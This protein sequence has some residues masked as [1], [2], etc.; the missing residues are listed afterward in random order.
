MQQLPHALTIDVEQ[1]ERQR[2]GHPPN[3]FFVRQPAGCRNAKQCAQINREL[4]REQRRLDRLRRQYD[5]KPWRSSDWEMQFMLDPGADGPRSSYLEVEQTSDQAYRVNPN[6][7]LDPLAPEDERWTLSPGSQDLAA[8]AVLADR[9]KFRVYP[10]MHSWQTT[11]ERSRARAAAETNALQSSPSMSLTGVNYPVPMRFI[12]G[13]LQQPPT[14][15]TGVDYDVETRG[16]P[17]R[18]PDWTRQQRLRH[19]RH[20]AAIVEQQHRTTDDSPWFRTCAETVHQRPGGACGRSVPAVYTSEGAPASERRALGQPQPTPDRTP[21]YPRESDQPTPFFQAGPPIPPPNPM[22]LTTVPSRLLSSRS[23]DSVEGFSGGPNNALTYVQP[24]GG[25]AFTANVASAP[26]KRRA[27]HTHGTEGTL[28]G[29]DPASPA[30]RP[31]EL[32]GYPEFHAARSSLERELLQTLDDTL[33]QQRRALMQIS[34]LRHVIA[35]LH[36]RVVESRARADPFDVATARA[37]SERAKASVAALR[38]VLRT[39]ER[40]R[41]QALRSLQRAFPD[42]FPKWDARVKQQ[43]AKLEAFAK[44]YHAQP[45]DGQVALYA[46]PHFAG[47][48]V[49]LGKG[50]HGAAATVGDNR[51]ASLKIGKDVTVRLYSRT[52][53]TGP[54]LTYVGPR[55][56]PTLPAMWDHAVSAIDVVRQDPVG[57]RAWD[58]PFFQGSEFRLGLGLHDYPRVGGLG[59]GRLSSLSIPD[60]LE[61]TLY[62]EREQRGER[63]TF[64]GPQRLSFLPVDWAQKVKGIRVSQRVFPRRNN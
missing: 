31:S 32:S 44:Q 12:L 50:S 47:K 38:E 27:A 37:K 36:Q 7:E 14:P 33:A 60:G 10:H 48:Q 52:D 13:P 1:L 64:L 42:K 55:R 63:I 5:Q 57:I 6:A 59:P 4:D 51:L 54:V 19:A 2:H 16:E 18:D 56:V 62:S 35:G 46:E 15:V 17:V 25:E 49:T 8:K 9:R 39:L 29:P 43:A 41:T 53:R 3:G 45:R 40:R 30:P 11:V 21:S 26:P 28:W 22:L 58:A 34:D 24:P 20:A 23:S 61:V